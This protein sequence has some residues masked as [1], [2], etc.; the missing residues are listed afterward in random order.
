MSI[1]IVEK[2]ASSMHQSS[3]ALHELTV[4]R[5]PHLHAP[6]PGRNLCT[7]P[8]SETALYRALAQN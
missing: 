3:Q 4:R 8:T 6:R 5:K 2:N 7:C 1:K